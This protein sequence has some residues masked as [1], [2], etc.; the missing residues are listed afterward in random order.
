MLSSPPPSDPRVTEA[1]NMLSSALN[2]RQSLSPATGMRGDHQG[3]G[4]RPLSPISA[5]SPD[6]SRNATRANNLTTTGA[7]SVRSSGAL[8]AD[9]SMGRAPFTTFSTRRTLNPADDNGDHDNRHDNG[10][11]GD[12]HDNGDHG[13]RHDN[14]DHGDRHV[15]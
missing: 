8:G 15:T 1:Q 5:R 10:D 11:H 4:L 14:G 9:S 13:D 7:N 3:S 6:A 12:R 2:L